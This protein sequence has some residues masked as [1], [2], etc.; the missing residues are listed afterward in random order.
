MRIQSLKNQD[1]A[2]GKKEKALEKT[3][4]NVRVLIIEEISMGVGLAVQ[5]A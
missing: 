4:K 3:W 1:M 5:Y 2:P